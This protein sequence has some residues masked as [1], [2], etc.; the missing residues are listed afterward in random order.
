MVSGIV[1]APVVATWDLHDV[2]GQRSSGLIPYTFEVT[3][4][5]V[6]PP[7]T[8][9]GERC[10]NV[11]LVGNS[12]FAAGHILVGALEDPRSV[13]AAGTFTVRMQSKGAAMLTVA[14]IA[15]DG[16]TLARTKR[17][18]LAADP[19]SGVFSPGDLYLV[20]LFERAVQIAKVLPPG[21]PID[22]SHIIPDVESEQ[23]RSKPPAG[24]D[25]PPYFPGYQE[26][27]EPGPDPPTFVRGRITWRDEAAVEYPAPGV[28]VCLYDDEDGPYDERL[29]CDYSGADGSYR[30][31]PFDRAAPDS[32]FDPTREFYVR[33]D[34]Q[35]VLTAVRPGPDYVDAVSIMVGAAAGALIAGGGTALAC[36]SPIVVPP[37]Y[38]LC[39]LMA[40]QWAVV[41]ASAGAAISWAV[42]NAVRSALEMCGRESYCVRSQIHDEWALVG[43]DVATF[44][45]DLPL[46]DL[47]RPSTDWGTAGDP[48]QIF[49]KLLDN[50]DHLYRIGAPFQPHQFPL[51]AN[52]PGSPFIVAGW[53]HG[54][55]NGCNGGACYEGHVTGQ[56]FFPGMVSYDGYQGDTVGHEFG[57]YVMHRSYGRLIP[58]DSDTLFCANHAFHLASASNCAIKE[59]FATFWA[60]A[61]GS[62]LDTSYDGAVDFNGQCYF[63]G[64]GCDIDCIEAPFIS[65]VE[66][67]VAMALFDLADPVPVNG[68]VRGGDDHLDQNGL[69]RIEMP[70]FLEAFYQAGQ[71]N[72]DIGALE[73]YWQILRGG[74]PCSRDWSLRLITREQ[75]VLGKGSLD[76]NLTMGIELCGSPRN[77][78]GRANLS[79]TA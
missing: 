57:H 4:T 37:A 28:R 32:L 17:H 2:G 8:T 72:I 48:G 70:V 79:Q 73:D 30:L 19:A 71:R 47:T 64:P 25:N 13:I 78:D 45:V 67:R 75:E 46:F 34:M 49:A 74:P 68:E 52:Y 18:V 59:G 1:H 20:R 60:V 3:V 38:A 35:T 14:A 76:Q 12:G 16:R 29:L 33:A 43:G 42:V 56:V 24:P 51:I 69:A 63:C 22:P 44:D 62:T 27:G 10:D 55:G 5:R 9:R 61:S 31:G 21:T 41:G 50:F 39:M 7:C 65:T 36:S 26:D 77:L 40:A 58:G 53:E 11:H 6:G 23:T 15:G 54:P 66:G